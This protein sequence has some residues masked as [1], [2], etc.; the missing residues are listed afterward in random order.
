MAFAINRN[1][2]FIDSMQ[3]MN[4]SLESLGK[5]LVDKDFKCLSEEFNG[6]YLRVV[7]EKGI[8]PYEY[9][10][11]LKKSSEDK[12]PKKSKFFSFLKDEDISK[13]DYEKAKNISNTFKIKTLGEYHDLYLKTDVLSLAYVFEKIINTCLNYY[14]LDPCYYVSSPGL[15]WDA[16]LKMTKVELEL[17]S[18]TDMLLFV[19]KGM[20]GGISCITKR[21]CKANNKYT[22]D[23]DSDKENIFILYLDANN[24]YG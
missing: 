17:I 23:Y 13:K 16:F 10:N 18:D 21:H 15:S 24:L 4:S 12:L 9:M 2:I 8:Y 20:R 14:G 5:K 11:S 19:E 6:E 22:K 1:L 7:K 3:F